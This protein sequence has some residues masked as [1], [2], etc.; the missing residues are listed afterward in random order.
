MGAFREK[1]PV[2]RAGWGLLNRDTGQALRYGVRIA[3]KGDNAMPG[4]GNS[5]GKIAAKSGQV[6]I[7]AGRG[8][9]V[10]G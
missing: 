5:G 7:C 2:P 8:G 10:A 1:G 6:L 4:G 9:T 3:G